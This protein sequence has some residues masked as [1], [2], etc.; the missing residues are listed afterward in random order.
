M[1]D[2]FHEILF[3]FSYSNSEVLRIL[4]FSFLFLLN[5]MKVHD[6]IF[7]PLDAV[8]KYLHSCMEQIRVRPLPL[9]GFLA[10]F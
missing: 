4:P 8:E 3:N 6:M 9:S 10:T 2:T 1:V 7:F 5:S